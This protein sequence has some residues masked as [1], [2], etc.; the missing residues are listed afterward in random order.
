MVDITEE[1]KD[2]YDHFMGTEIFTL[3]LRKILIRAP[4]I[5]KKL[6]TAL[7]WICQPSCT[8][9]YLRRNGLHQLP[10]LVCVTIWNYTLQYHLTHDFNKLFKDYKTLIILR[11]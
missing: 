3:I 9:S 10:Q 6:A 5:M 2:L 1:D 7:I 11:G 4:K 8:N